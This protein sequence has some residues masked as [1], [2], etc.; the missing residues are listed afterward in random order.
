MLLP[1]LSRHPTQL[2][3]PPSHS[4][5]PLIGGFWFPLLN[6]ITLP[7]KPLTALTRASMDQFIAAPVVLAGFFT[8]VGAMEGKGGGEIREK[9][10]NVRIW[11]GFAGEWVLYGG[12][13]GRVDGVVKGL[14]SCG[15]EK[16]D[17]L[18]DVQSCRV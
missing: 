14:G 18:I 11:G 4:F 8:V 5:A 2:T 7:S 1:I 10:E 17:E 13:M 12:G 9:V 15:R 6:R 3:S 16:A